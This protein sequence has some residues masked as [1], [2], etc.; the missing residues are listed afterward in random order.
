MPRVDSVMHRTTVRQ[1]GMFGSE[2]LARI[3]GTVVYTNG[4]SLEVATTMPLKEYENASIPEQREMINKLL[5]REAKEEVDAEER[6]REE[7]RE[8]RANQGR[9]DAAGESEGR[10][11]ADAGAEAKPERAAGGREHQGLDDDTREGVPHA[12]RDGSFVQAGHGDEKPRDDGNADY[13]GTRLDPQGERE[14]PRGQEKGAG[15]FQDGGTD[16]ETVKSNPKEQ[17]ASGAGGTADQSKREPQ[18]SNEQ[19]AAKA[20]GELEKSSQ[21]R[22]SNPGSSLSER[23]DKP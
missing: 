20:P 13:T 17:K 5:R 21:T 10:R 16:K 14:R 15:D 8:R 23:K 11:E 6:A 18:R 19:Q 3:E 9:G 1:E 7:R 2:P 12:A 4:E 22:L